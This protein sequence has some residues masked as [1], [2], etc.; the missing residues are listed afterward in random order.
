MLEPSE[1]LEQIRDLTAG[2]GVDKAVDCSGVVAAHRL[3]ID[4]ARRRGMVAFVGESQAETP[5]VI[6]PD[7]IRKGLTLVGSWH[8][9]LKD[10]PTIMRIIQEVGPQLDQLITHRF[11]LDDVQVA[12]ETQA[13][14]NCGKVILKPWQ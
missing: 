8:Y 13:A 11:A 14:G 1:A 10:T 3:C 4:A 6:S 9:N 2:K 7:M 5:L 12:W